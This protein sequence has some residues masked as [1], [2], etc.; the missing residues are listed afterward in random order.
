VLLGRGRVRVVR[1]RIF[2]RRCRWSLWLRIGIGR[3]LGRLQGFEGRVLATTA[4]Q[5][6]RRVLIDMWRRQPRGMIR[7]H[8]PRRRRSAFPCLLH[9]RIWILRP[10]Q[11]RWRG[12][13][14]RY[15]TRKSPSLLCLAMHSQRRGHSRRLRLL[16][17]RL[18][19]APQRPLP[20]VRC[21]C[22][23]KQVARLD[24]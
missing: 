20:F 21:S 24:L 14:S 19:R 13:K 7:G 23:V 5:E 6:T 22:L 18:L 10:C 9:Q 1:G 2:R 4:M 15:S 16:V 12:V 17:H 8:H 3:G 11:R